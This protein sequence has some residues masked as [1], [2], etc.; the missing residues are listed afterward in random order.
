M[1]M[2]IRVFDSE[3]FGLYIIHTCMKALK[4]V[5]IIVVYHTNEI[6][7]VCEVSGSR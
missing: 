6:V 1:D 5:L 7:R 2:K 3:I 4:F